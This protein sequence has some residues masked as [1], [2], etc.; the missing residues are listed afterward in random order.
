M[1]D[2]QHKRLTPHVTNETNQLRKVVLGLPHALGTP[3]TLEETYDAKS[4]QAVLRGDYPTEQAVVREMEGF[5]AI[6][7][8][9]G[10]EVYRPEPIEACNQIF[11][12]DVSFVIDEHLFV[13]HMIPDRRRE[14]DAFASIYDLFEPSS[15]LHLPAEVRVEGGDVILYDDILFVGCC[16][17]GAFGQFKTTRTNDRAVDFFREFFPHKRIVP[18]PLYKH[19]QD[20]LRGVLHL[21]CAFQPVGRGFAVFYPEGVASREARGIIGEVFGQDKLLTITAEEAVEMHTNFFSLSPEEVC[22]EAGAERLQRYLREVAGMTVEE[23]PYSEIS[24]QGGL[25]RC[26][27]CPLERA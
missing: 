4:Y 12:R 22:V 2:K 1:M 27:T 24:K 26:S 25:L 23:V 16:E 20:P 14:V 9:H 17:P 11:A 18:V 21:D 5:L 8:R 6:L 7:Q 10:V 13:A 3:P 19:D 15:V